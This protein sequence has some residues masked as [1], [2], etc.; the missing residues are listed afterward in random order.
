M[1]SPAHGRRPHGHLR[2]APGA[3]GHPAGLVP[4]YSAA[5]Q[6]SAGVAAFGE[7]LCGTCL[8]TVVLRENTRFELTDVLAFLVRC[9]LGRFCV[10]FD[11]VWMHVGFS[12]H[13]F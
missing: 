8:P 7:L 1:Q 9:E 5:S 6:G 11:H 4:P 3:G 2:R 10:A 12:D 13:N